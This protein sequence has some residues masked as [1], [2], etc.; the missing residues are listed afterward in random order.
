M[1]FLK[2]EGWQCDPQN[3][4]KTTTIKIGNVQYEKSAFIKNEIKCHSRVDR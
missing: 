2:C 1:K 4:V 3:K